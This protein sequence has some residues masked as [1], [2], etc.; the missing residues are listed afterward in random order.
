MAQP[1]DGIRVLDLTRVMTGPYC[2]MMLGDMGADVV[3]IEQPGK[4]DDTRPWGPP[5]LAGESA[6]FLSINRNKRSVTVD[7][8]HERGR[9]IVRRL[10]ARAD[11]VVEN[12]RPGAAGRLGLG[13]ADVRALRPDVVYC[14]ISGFGQDGPDHDRTAYDLIV[15]GMSGMMSITGAAGGMPTKMGVPI[16]DMTAGMFAAFAIVNGLFHR[17]RTG[18]GQY[19]DTSMLGAQ[20]ALLVYYATG[21][22]A[23]GEVPTRQGNRHATVTPYDTF[24]T[25]DGYVNVGVGNDSL[26]RRF[27][28]AFD[29]EGAAADERFASNAARVANSEPLYALINE[30]LRRH[31][32]A[33]VMAKL[34]AVGVPAGPIETLDQVFARPQTLHLGLQ[35]RVAHPTIG[36][37]AMPGV[38]YRLSATPCRTRQAPPLLGQHTDDVLAELGYGVDEIAALREAGAV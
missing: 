6:Y 3:K 2:T 1:L 24:P 18:E 11:V 15:Q 16:A 21:Y 17:A 5:F 14:S 22:F 23:T 37:V 32:T 9:E 26:W 13:Y 29:L 30:T 25:A 28:G 31:T 8:K 19:I 34:D 4:G 27:C 38:P 35:Q 36:E 10:A 33:E 12:F 20:V 7:L